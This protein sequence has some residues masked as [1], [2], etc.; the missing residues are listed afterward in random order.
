MGH[1]NKR[2]RTGRTTHV[3]GIGAPTEDDLPSARTTATVSSAA[4]STRSVQ[5]AHVPAL[6]NLCARAFVHHLNYLC[7]EE[8]R[9]EHQKWWLQALP[10]HIIPRL[11]AIMRTEVPD[12]LISPFITTVRC[13]K[14]AVVPPIYNS[15]IIIS[16][17]YST[18][19]VAPQ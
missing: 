10:D 2:R 12:K 6:T 8:Q 15:C 16:L 1:L 17:L 3:S 18:S 9:W 13:L 19:S 5:A 14:R 7:K 11:F 4:L